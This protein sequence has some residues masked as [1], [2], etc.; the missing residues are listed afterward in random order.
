MAGQKREARLHEKSRP[1]TSSLPRDCKAV[2]AR[3]KPGMTVLL[4]KARYA[5]AAVSDQYLSRSNP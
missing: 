2:D 5:F 4:V 1:S 3:D